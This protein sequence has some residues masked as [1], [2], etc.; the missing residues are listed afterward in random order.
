MVLC[1][2]IKRHPPSDF[3]TKWLLNC[4]QNGHVFIILEGSVFWLKEWRSANRSKDTHQVIFEL[5]T[6][7]SL[8]KRMSFYNSWGVSFLAKKNGALPTDQKTPVKWFLNLWLFYCCSRR[9]VFLILEGS[10]F[11]LKEWRSANWSKDTHQVIF[12]LND[13]FI[14]VKMDVFL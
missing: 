14:V 1:Q 8:F 4:C 10:V 7:I 6:F 3:W 2:P 11:W 12:E 9:W 5:M 13:F